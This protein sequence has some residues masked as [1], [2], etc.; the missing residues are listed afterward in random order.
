M[1][2]TDAEGCETVDFIEIDVRLIRNV[3]IPNTFNPNFAAPNNRFMILTG[4]GVQE[5]M[6]FRIFDRWGN[7]V[8]DI[9]GPISAPTNPD[10]GW[11]G[12]RGNAA[13][14]DCEQGVYVYI[15]EVLFQDGG[16]PILYQG[17]VTLLR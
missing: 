10:M 15:A 2:V 1:N 9:G 12:R 17:S 7:K 3:Y 5:I 4:Q 6:S 16:Q 14:S 13:N 8:F 11:D